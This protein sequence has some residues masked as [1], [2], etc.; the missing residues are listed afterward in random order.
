MRFNFTKDGEIMRLVAM[1]MMHNSS[2]NCS[3]PIYLSR[4]KGDGESLL[5]SASKTTV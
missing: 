3:P 4:T 5:M 1:G 2:W